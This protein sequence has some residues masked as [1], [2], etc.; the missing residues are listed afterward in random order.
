MRNCIYFDVE[1]N[2]PK[3]ISTVNNHIASGHITGQG[4]CQK[5]SQTLQF[6]SLPK[7]FH[8][9]PWCPVLTKWIVSS[10]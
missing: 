10:S 7:S 8:G 9:C 3:H 6:W 2:S 4:R 1:A 5:Y